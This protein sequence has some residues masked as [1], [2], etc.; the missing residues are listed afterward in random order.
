MLRLLLLILPTMLLAACAGLHADDDQGVRS[1]PPTALGLYAQ[2]RLAWSNGE[3][4]RALDLLHAAQSVDPHSAQPYVAEAEIRMKVN[5]IKEALAVLDKAIKIDPTY[6]DA[7][8]LAGA[9]MANLGRD[10]EAVGYLRTAVKLDPAKEDA[11]LELVNSLLRLYEYEESVNVLKELIRLK[12]DS[13]AGYYYL[14]KTYSQMKL[15]RE[16][17]GYYKQAL[18]LRPDFFQ[19]AVDQ[20]VSLEALGE[21]DQA[22]AA[23]R[24]LVDETE[25]RA[26][27]LNHLVQLLIQQRRYEDALFYLHKLSAMGLDSAEVQRKIGLIDLELG[28]YDEAIAVFTAMLNREP[29]NHQLRFYLASAFEDK[30]ALDQAKA[31]F[32]RIPADS[33]VYVEALGHLAFILKEQGDAAGAVRLLQNGIAAS[34]NR[35]ELYLTL[36]TLYDALDRDQ[37][38]LEL[39]L[40]A[41]ARFKDDPRFQFRLGVLDDKLGKRQESIQRMKRVIELNP[42][43][44]QALNYLGYTYAE[45]G[46]NLHEALDYIKRALEIRPDD[47]FFL[48]SLGWVYYQLKRYDEAIRELG[49][50]AQLL[51]DD[52][53]VLEHLG[54]AYLA[55]HEPKKAV[56]MY[57]KALE[58]DTDKHALEEK[59]RRVLKGELDER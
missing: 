20:A 7:Y 17:L 18:E 43:D 4:D 9:I 33:G 34:P 1:I 24:K 55:H 27:I 40:G 13:A 5:Q 28:R 37:D 29:D 35:L 51:N 14:G 19:A 49:R 52:P 57:K 8:L 56:R 32:M 58:L 46:I 45:M 22:I 26:P 39:L 41:E 53:T 16:A 59:I 23:Y 10:R 44:P 11:V 48:D 6:R 50:A 21:F 2:A 15:F 38:G 54:D 25:N 47:G 12:P 3:G 42:R 30:G 31:E 36:A